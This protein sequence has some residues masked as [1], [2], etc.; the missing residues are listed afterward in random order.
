MH[1]ENVDAKLEENPQHS[2]APD[3]AAMSALMAVVEACEDGEKGYREAASDV[4]D[5]G[6]RLIFAHY[7][8]QRAGFAR[9]LNDAF[10]GLRVVPARGGSTGAAIHRDWLE[11]KAVLTGGSAKAVLTECRRGEDVAL[12]TYHAALRHE[13]LPPDIREMVQEQYEAVKTARAE[14]AALEGVADS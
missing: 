8:D 6:Y 12:E 14:I 10:R 11:A 4:R 5:S 3:D 1:R 2:Q 7:A 9:A 13:D